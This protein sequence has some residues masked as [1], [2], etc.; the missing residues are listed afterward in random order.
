LFQ[1]VGIDPDLERLK[2]AREKYSADNIEFL[3][4]SAEELPL[5][6]FDAIF[7][8]FVLHWCKEKAK[9]FK[10]VAKRLQEGGKFGF[11]IPADFDNIETFF[12]PASMFNSECREVMINTM[13]I[14]CSERVKELLLESNF[15]IAKLEKHE[16][17]WVF[18]DVNELIEFYMTHLKD[19]TQ[20]AFNFEAMKHHYG[21]GKIVITT[22]YITVVATKQ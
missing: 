2:I 9:I 4:K 17:D 11:V 18:N 13:H 19:Q 6:Q 14:P 22:S 15:A 7:S 21:D 10:E 5:Q 16:V 12:T 1:V 8:N 20:K 3:E